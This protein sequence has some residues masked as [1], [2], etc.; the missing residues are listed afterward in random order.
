[1]DISVPGASL[2]IDP[3]GLAASAELPQQF[4]FNLDYNSGD[5]I[6]LSEPFL[7]TFARKLSD[8]WNIRLDAIYR[9]LSETRPK[10]S[11]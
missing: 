1:M 7:F 3:R 6:G 4:P 10:T 11:F 8:M 5:T 9:A 2:A